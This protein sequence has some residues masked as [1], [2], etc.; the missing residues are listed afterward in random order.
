[1]KFGLA[2]SGGGAR[3]MAHL[4]IIKGL[5]EM[6][7][8]FSQVSGTSAGAIAGA[9]YC[10]G[11][12]PDEIFDIIIKTGFLKS[13]RPAWAWTGLLSMDGF[14]EVM[15]RC[16]PEDD[17]NALKIPL[18]VAATEIRLGKIVYFD[19]GELTAAVLASSSI[20]ALFNPV[21][22]NGNVYVDGGLMDNLPVTPL[23]GKCDYIVGSHCN[24]VE[25]RF[26]LK[27]VKDI[28]ERSLLVAINVGTT[29]SKA[30]CNKVIEPPELGAF[31]TFDLARGKEIFKIGY[32]YTQ[33]NYKAIDFQLNEIL[34]H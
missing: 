18:T 2:L 3:G 5:E 25:Q 17:F 30:Q 28:T 20:P 16:M 13:V 7:L 21:A 23:V 6:G 27:S 4:G 1:M 33:A 22:F 34:K 31:S 32:R 29:H 14:K 10:Y 26:D 15:K 11:Y 9:F 12:K 8:R 19:Q 24:P